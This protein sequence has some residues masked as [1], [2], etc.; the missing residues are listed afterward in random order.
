MPAPL[1]AK[2]IGPMK[3]VAAKYYPGAPVIPTMSTGASDALYLMPV[4]IPTYGVPGFSS[5]PEGSGAHGLNEHSSVRS[6]YLGRDY[7]TDLVRTLADAG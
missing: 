2:V 3:K 4:G 6:V 7:L 5:G 1:D